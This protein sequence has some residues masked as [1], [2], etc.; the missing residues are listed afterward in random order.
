MSRKKKEVINKSLFENVEFPTTVMCVSQPNRNE[1]LEGC[2]YKAVDRYTF[3]NKH[4]L[5]VL[6]HDGREV[7]FSE[8]HF[9]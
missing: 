3:N 7:Y 8:E 4:Y 5:V 2:E 1:I 9:A 6:T